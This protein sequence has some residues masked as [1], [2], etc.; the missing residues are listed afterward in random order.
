MSSFVEL[1]FV[2]VSCAQTE[3][4]DT[5][6]HLVALGFVAVVRLQRR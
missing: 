3:V 5:A 4:V 1:L 2:D 6:V